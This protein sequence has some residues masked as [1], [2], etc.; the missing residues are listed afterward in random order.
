MDGG[1]G[2][3]TGLR[4]FIYILNSILAM[5]AALAIGIKYGGAEGFTLYVL[6]TNLVEIAHGAAK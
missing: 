5:G 4:F 1:E 2:E 6:L 3:M